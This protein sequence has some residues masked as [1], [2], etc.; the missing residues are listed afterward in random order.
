MIDKD[1]LTE[2]MEDD[3]K[4]QK[5]MEDLDQEKELTDEQQGYHDAGLRPSD[6]N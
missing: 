3:R 4:E 6:F 5:R 2:L 1:K